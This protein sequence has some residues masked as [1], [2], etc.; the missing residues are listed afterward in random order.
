MRFAVI[1]F[2]LFLLFCISSAY[3]AKPSVL[4]IQTPIEGFGRLA[5]SAAQEWQGA[6]FEIDQCAPDEVS[7]EKIKRF[8]VLVLQGMGVTGN[9]YKLLPYMPQNE[10]LYAR[11][12][13]QGGGIFF[14]PHVAEAPTTM[15][16]IW[17]FGDK[18][19]V[20]PLLEE[21]RDPATQRV[22]GGWSV[23]YAY[24]MGIAPHPVTAGVTGIWYPSKRAKIYPYTMPLLFDNSW[25]VLL[26]TS[27]TAYSVPF[28][29]YTPQIDTRGR[30][31]GDKGSIPIYAAREFPEGGRMIACGLYP[32]FCFADPFAQALE[33]VSISKGLNG[34]PSGLRTVLVQSLNW[35]AQPSLASGKLGGALT[36]PDTL[37]NTNLLDPKD[38][39]KQIPWETLKFAAPKTSYK[40][41]IGAKSVLTG[42]KGT[43]A[44]YV[45]AAKGT[46]YAWLVFLEDFRQLTP[47]K[48]L[49]HKQECLTAS[50]PDFQVIPGYYI[51][52]EFGGYWAMMGDNAVLPDPRI[53][54]VTNKCFAQPP[55]DKEFRGLGTALCNFIFGQARTGMLVASF[56]HKKAKYPYYDYRN[57][58]AIALYT[59]RGA[60]MLDQVSQAGYAYLQ[61]RGENLLPLAITLLDSPA[62]IPAAANNFACYA[63]L[64]SLAKIRGEFTQWHMLDNPHFYVSNGPTVE[65][66]SW[67]GDR[68]YSQV[69]S[70]YNLSGY[71]WQVRL[72]ANSPV[73]IKSV[74]ILSGPN[75]T[76]RRFLGN[77]QPR[78]ECQLPLVHNQ[79]KNLV[80]VVTDAQGRQAIT[81]EAFDRS[82]L[83]EEFMCGDRN[84]QLFYS[85]QARPDGSKFQTGAGGCGV[86]PNK[87][88]WHGEMSAN[89]FKWDYQWGGAI[90]GFDGAPY[91]EPALFFNPEFRGAQT[92]GRALHGRPE[93]VLNSADVAISEVVSDG[94]FPVGTDV[95]NVWH[96]LAPLL[97]HDQFRVTMRTYYFSP[98]P[99]GMST[100][101]RELRIT[102]L[103]SF[104]AASGKDLSLRVMKIDARQSARW[105]LRTPG[106]AVKE[107]AVNEKQYISSRYILHP[108]FYWAYFD[109]PQG[110]AAI[111]PL[112]HEWRGNLIM[113]KPTTF[114]IEM[115]LGNWVPAGKDFVFRMVIAGV[116]MGQR[117]NPSLFESFRSGFGIGSEPRY[118]VKLEKGHIQDRQFWLKV[119]AQDGGF[120]G[121]IPKCNLPAR[122]PILVTGI[123]DRWSVGYYDRVT[124]KYR[125]LGSDEGT[126]YAVTDP[127]ERTQ[128]LFIGHPFT[129]D[130]PEVYLTFV[131]T[132]EH[133]GQIDLHNPTD[134]PL[135]VHVKRSPSF[136]WMTDG[137]FTVTVPAGSS[138]TRKVPE[139]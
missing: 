18:Y 139:R 86:T 117:A 16:P 88:P 122:L 134:K 66:Y 40:G 26:R 116:H 55:G 2:F 41:L 22:A 105:R 84:N 25:Q 89:V 9:D 13:Q 138:V 124:G 130:Q 21:I 83:F 113:P 131:P 36:N 94:T 132:G 128:H 97:P 46:G 77:N 30:K 7:W 47:E 74:D 71:R 52:D 20:T 15:P 56:Y 102:T 35:L 37:K 85:M 87:G 81:M 62:V 4:F 23:P 31:A 112:T 48:W 121:E 5:Y 90:Q 12:L 61:Q 109:S 79:Q 64:D 91:G 59:Y 135:T 38:F 100:F 106:S 6:G 65:D 44:E 14:N 115:P 8:N 129:C 127:A 28:S 82:H 76:F 39:D 68:D 1:P 3:A 75:K 11:F 80:A 42:G 32:A 99:D 60:E 33:G 98:K 29:T 92:Q 73:G 51:T 78:V 57:Y 72:I 120:A 111:Y 96:T 69:L 126:A 34:K 95:S 118:Q 17:S 101:V 103:K 133:A 43:V 108:G 27:V 54:D 114:Y 119:A 107:G 19:G 104:S 45:K 125:P 67:I 53:V 49:Q 24:T 70:W 137:E 123:N 58:D 63:Q 93:R 50:T 136:N 110:G 10:E